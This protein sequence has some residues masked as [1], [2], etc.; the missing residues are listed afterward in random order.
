MSRDSD[1]RLAVEQLLMSMSDE[2][3]WMRV[4]VLLSG[5]RLSPLA[6]RGLDALVS[7]R[8]TLYNAYDLFGQDVPESMRARLKHLIQVGEGHYTLEGLLEGIAR[9]LGEGGRVAMMVEEAYRDLIR[10]HSDRL[11][12]FRLRVALSGAPLS[13]LG[14][15]GLEFLLD[16][17]I[18]L[19]LDRRGYGLFYGDIP[20]K[21]RP[22]LHRMEG[23]SIGGLLESL[24]EWAEA[25]Q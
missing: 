6:E 10:C 12:W 7:H 24:G 11:D 13:R 25:N 19:V 18:T 4:S 3:D 21:L 20:E 15:S 8:M 23:E 2:V 17:Q 14:Q 22:A 9:A 5:A 16:N 1:V